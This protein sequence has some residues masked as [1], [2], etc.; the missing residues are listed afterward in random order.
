M[1]YCVPAAV[2]AIIENIDDA[3]IPEKRYSELSPEEFEALKQ[4]EQA[5]RQATA[6][7]YFAEETVDRASF[8]EMLA[9]E[10]RE[11]ARTFGIEHCQTFG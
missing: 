11:F 9:P 4:R 3:T 6:A 5:I 7:R 2:P 10:R 1:E 8:Y